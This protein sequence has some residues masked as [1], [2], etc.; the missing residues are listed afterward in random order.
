MNKSPSIPQEK[1]KK[2]LIIS[3]S[4]KMGGIERALC[5]LANFF[6]TQKVEVV[7]LSCLKSDPFYALDERVKVIDPNFV[8]K[9]GVVDKIRFYPQLIAFIRRHY[10]LEKPNAVLSFGDAFNP[11]VLLALKDVNAPI[12][13]SDRTSPDYNFKFPIPYLKKWLY[14]KSAG[15]IAQTTRAANFKRKQFG[16]KLNIKIIPN[17]LKEM[18]VPGTDREK[19]VLYV[20]R[21]AWEKAPQYLVEAF[22][23]IENQ[24]EWRLVMAGTGPLW[25]DMK[26]LA[27]QLGINDRVDFLGEVQHVDAL[28]ARASIYV[29]PSVIEGF[30]NSL[31]E[32]M[33]AGLPAICFDTIPHEDVFVY[34][35]MGVVC[36]ELSSKALSQSIESLIADKAYREELGKNAAKLGR[37]LNIGHIGDRYLKFMKLTHVE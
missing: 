34:P 6:V 18:N 10:K 33:A 30:P 20:G 23:Q 16:D 1:R 32:A 27:H 37:Y 31:C 22:S 35:N 14:P 26:T 13:I 21:F 8:R 17:A 15:F 3:P 28:Y 25:N 5:N 24:K 11:L 2:L 9:R 29:L 12:Y 19:I 4:L 7:F 36:T